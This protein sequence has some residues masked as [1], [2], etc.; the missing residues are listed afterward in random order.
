MK[1]EMTVCVIFNRLLD[2]TILGLIQQSKLLKELEVPTVNL[3]TFCQSLIEWLI[4]DNGKN[5]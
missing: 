3:R 2:E 5:K 1:L 4:S